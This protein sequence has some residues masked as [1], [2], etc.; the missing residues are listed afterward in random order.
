MGSSENKKK[1]LKA[2]WDAAIAAVSGAQAVENAIA[3]DTPYQPDMIIAVGKAAAGMCRG[4]M[5][6]QTGSCEAIIVT[7]RE[8]A[9][10]ELRSRERMTLIESGHPIP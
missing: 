1:A 2:I 6:F 5:N 10:Q 3:A 4:A 7:K 8:H 9:D